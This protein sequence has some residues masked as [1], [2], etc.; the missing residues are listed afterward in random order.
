MGV[1]STL[2]KWCDSYYLS[3]FCYY[4]HKM[5]STSVL[6]L[7]DD[8]FFLSGS[9]LEMWQKCPQLFRVAKVL[10]RETN[11]PKPG[12]TFGAIVH[13]AMACNYANLDKLPSERLSLIETVLTDEFAKSD[14]PFDN[15]RNLSYAMNLFQAYMKQYPTEP[16]EIM[17]HEGKQVIERSFNEPLIQLDFPALHPRP[18]TV[19][20]IGIVDTMVN[21]A[22]GDIETVDH[23]TSKRGGQTFFD[24]FVSDISQIGYVWAMRRHG[25]DV[26]SFLVNGLI[27]P[28]P[29]KSGAVN[30]QFLRQRVHVDDA[31]LA[32]WESNVTMLVESMFR[33]LA[34]GDF[35]LYRHNCVG[36]YGRCDLYQL[37][38]Y[39][40]TVW[41]TLVQGD[42]FRDVKRS[43]VY[44][45]DNE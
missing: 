14:M 15:Y 22:N 40:H 10:R 23:K 30:W 43:P 13:K 32:E 41:D 20:W 34:T 31:K 12:R 6:P 4:L 25:Y 37:H 29:L 45:D 9:T 17:H 33:Q 16:F 44:G 24:P 19:N 3:T 26:R 39:N 21:Y 11:E 28:E 2:D 35:P 8:T 18:I 5:N 7:V 1:K 42:M 38:T 36:K 27:V